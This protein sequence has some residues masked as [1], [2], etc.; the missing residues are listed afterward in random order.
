[1][2]KTSLKEY[3]VFFFTAIAF[4]FVFAQQD[5]S[6]A[7]ELKFPGNEKLQVLWEFDSGG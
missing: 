6:G 2:K 4:L 7:N 3:H 1:M 5:I